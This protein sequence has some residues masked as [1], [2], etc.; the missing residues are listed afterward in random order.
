MA[1]LNYAFRFT[2]FKNQSGIRAFSS[3][4]A[5]G[6]KQTVQLPAKTCYIPKTQIWKYIDITFTCTIHLSG[7]KVYT[8]CLA[9]GGL[10][11]NI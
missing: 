6:D 1:V 7:K 3:T 11:L 10:F 4:P 9:M 2:T 5:E 8:T